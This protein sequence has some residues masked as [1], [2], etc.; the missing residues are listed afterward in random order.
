MLGTDDNL[1]LV[2]HN[3]FSASASYDPITTIYVNTF[4]CTYCKYMEQFAELR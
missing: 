3:A 4:F 2:N 1:G